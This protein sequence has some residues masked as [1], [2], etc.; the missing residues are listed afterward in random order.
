MMVVEVVVGYCG[1][2]AL[3]RVPDPCQPW[4]VEPAAI[5]AD[6]RHSPLP[7]RVAGKIVGYCGCD[8]VEKP[9]DGERLT[10]VGSVD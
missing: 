5:A 7:G 6:V 10:H 1:R 8:A 4:A 9:L 2:M 3:L